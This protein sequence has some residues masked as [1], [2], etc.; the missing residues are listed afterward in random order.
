MTSTDKMPDMFS[1]VRQYLDELQR[2]A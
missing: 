2:S 1:P